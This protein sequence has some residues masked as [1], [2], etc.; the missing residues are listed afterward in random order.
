MG[1]F[2]PYTVLDQHDARLSAPDQGLD[3][4]RVVRDVRQRLGRDHDII[5]A[6]G[7]GV[8]RTRRVGDT[9]VDPVRLE[10][11]VAETVRFESDAGTGD[12]GVIGAADQRYVNVGRGLNHSQFVFPFAFLYLMCH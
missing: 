6:L 4:P 11:V 8:R 1:V 3:V 12:G 7:R 9:R 10:M 2:D 5:P